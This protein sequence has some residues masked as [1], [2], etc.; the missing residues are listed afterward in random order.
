M[1]EAADRGFDEALEVGLE[2]HTCLE[3]FI[4]SLF[5]E[6]REGVEVFGNL[7]RLGEG[8]CV[9]EG[10]IIRLIRRM[11]SVSNLQLMYLMTLDSLV[12]I[13]SSFSSITP[14]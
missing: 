4:E 6:F 14:P 7:T 8:C 1:E 5:V 12:V 2:V 3:Q 10:K 9:G 13:A 11:I